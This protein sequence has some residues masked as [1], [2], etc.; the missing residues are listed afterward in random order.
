MQITVTNASQT[1]PALLWPTNEATLEKY[2]LNSNILWPQPQYVEVTI[3]NTQ[4]AETIY[5][6]LYEAATVNSLPIAVNTERT[7]RVNSIQYVNLIGS[8][9]T[10][11]A[12]VSVQTA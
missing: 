1:L 3:R 7:F 6:E 12:I 5:V 11:T 2:V 10:C 8:A 9:A 4:A